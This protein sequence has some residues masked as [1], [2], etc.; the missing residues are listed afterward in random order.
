MKGIHNIY[1]VPD[2]THNLLSAGKLIEHGYKVLFEV[3]PSRIYDKTPN[4]KLIFEIHMTRNRMFPLTLR[5]ANL[6]QSYAQSSSTPIE[7]MVWHTRF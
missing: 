3:A 5:T 4:R 1:H 7:T 6:I 2:M